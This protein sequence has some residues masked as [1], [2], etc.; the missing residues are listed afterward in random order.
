MCVANMVP[1]RLQLWCDH[2]NKQAQ[3]TKQHIRLNVF[4]IVDESH[5]EMMPGGRY[6]AVKICVP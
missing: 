5:Y 3:Y 6:S 1:I 2:T 4:M